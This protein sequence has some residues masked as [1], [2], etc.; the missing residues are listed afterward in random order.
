[1]WQG[2]R[3]GRG[4]GEAERVMRRVAGEGNEDRDEGKRH[5]RVRS[6]YPN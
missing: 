6:K 1:M 5:R 2:S 4:R 3:E